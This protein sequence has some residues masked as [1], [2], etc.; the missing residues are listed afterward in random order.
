MIRTSAA[1]LSKPLHHRGSTRRS[2]HQHP[3]VRTLALAP[4]LLIDRAH[5]SEVSD[6]LP[7]WDSTKYAHSSNRA[8]PRL[9]AFDDVSTSER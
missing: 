5:T 6:R 2:Q 4:Q 1:G 7:G 8:S 9:L 3:F